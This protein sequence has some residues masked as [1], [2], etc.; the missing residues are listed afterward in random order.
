MVDSGLTCFLFPVSGSLQVVVEELGWMDFFGDAG[1][2]REGAGG[3][4]EYLVSTARWVCEQWVTDF[5]EVSGRRKEAEVA[6]F[7][8]EW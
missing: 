1:V 6:S 4:A 3:R 8:R 7:L 5:G 2:G